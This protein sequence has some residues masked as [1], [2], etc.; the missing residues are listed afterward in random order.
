MSL[1]KARGFPLYIVSYGLQN[2]LMKRTAV[3]QAI[4]NGSFVVISGLDPYQTYSVTLGVR[5]L[6]GSVS[7]D[8][9]VTS[10]SPIESGPS[11]IIY[12][13]YSFPSSVFSQGI[14]S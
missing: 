8:V 10:V 11:T 12:G 2:S 6:A 4:S 14:S 3:M 13:Q 9:S 5:T 7:S 1:A